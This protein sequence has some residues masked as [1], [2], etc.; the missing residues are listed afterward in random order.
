MW[1]WRYWYFFDR[2][3]YRFCRQILRDLCGKICRT[4]CKDCRRSGFARSSDLAQEAHRFAENALIFSVCQDSVRSQIGGQV[5]DGVNAGAHATLAAGNV[6]GLD[7][8]LDA[9][10]H[11][12]FA[13]TAI[14]SNG[15]D[16]GPA[17]QGVDVG[18]AAKGNKDQFGRGVEVAGSPSVL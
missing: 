12:A 17:L 9:S 6:A 7:Q 16:A 3:H 2:F 13:Q 8:F 18:A 15:A 10:A 11:S 4:F 5:F 1:G 14:G